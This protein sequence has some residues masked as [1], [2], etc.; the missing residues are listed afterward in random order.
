MELDIERRE[1]KERWTERE[2]YSKYD[3]KMDEFRAEVERECVV[4]SNMD[5]KDLKTEAKL[6]NLILKL[7]R[8]TAQKEIIVKTQRFDGNFHHHQGC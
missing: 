2:F 1:K 7:N 6:P 4:R 5:I 8:N 3:R